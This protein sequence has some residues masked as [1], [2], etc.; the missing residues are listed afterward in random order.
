[1]NKAL[2]EAELAGTHT[3]SRP[4]DWRKAMSDNVALA[5]LV[6]TGMQI[7][8]T[9]G[10]MKQGVSSIVPYLALVVLVAG[11]IPA[12]RWFERRWS[13]LSDDDAAD[14]ALKPAFRRDQILLWVLAIGLPAV[15]TAFFKL[16]F[17]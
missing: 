9:V 14:I 5:L 17:S 1:M 16:I 6:Y 2:H 11:I 15:L 7:F 13:H 3:A 12:C 8:M 10:A 4:R